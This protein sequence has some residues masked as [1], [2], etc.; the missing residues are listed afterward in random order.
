MIS[1]SQTS[2]QVTFSASAVTKFTVATRKRITDGTRGGLV[3]IR[4]FEIVATHYGPKQSRLTLLIKDFHSLGSDGSGTFGN[5]VPIELRQ[6]IRV[7][8]IQ[9][10]E[11]R[12][13]EPTNGQPHSDLGDDVTAS[14]IRSQATDGSSDDE[15]DVVTQT[16][17]A[18]QGMRPKYNGK[19]MSEVNIPPKRA[20]TTETLISNGAPR[21]S[22]I[23]LLRPGTGS[24][25]NHRALLDLLTMKNRSGRV[26]LS[27]VTSD[28]SLAQ[29]S[30]RVFRQNN[31][32]QPKVSDKDDLAF[33]DPL[34]RNEAPRHTMAP[35]TIL[36]AT[37]PAQAVSMQSP[38]SVSDQFPKDLQNQYL[39]TSDTQSHA[40]A[41]ETTIHRSGSK[42][43]N[44]IPNQ[45]AINHSEYALPTGSNASPLK[46]DDNGT[47]SDEHP[48][49]VRS[50]IAIAL[51]GLILGAREW[52][53]SVEGTS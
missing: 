1:D 44:G 22:S 43:S 52:S 50:S 26:P 47:E 37:H 18:T 35:D 7:P 48:W 38:E 21:E 53:R 10:G 3:Q 42:L 25:S 31:E 8:L 23:S 6:D 2:I 51:Q 16:A 17:F 15:A 45:G 12:A 14:D 46:M 4:A 29:G 41:R 28:P 34:A 27:A 19:G 39:E 40:F 13:Q 11:L 36:T 9:L 30:S 49:M 24:S 33:P 20:K 32:D 5:P